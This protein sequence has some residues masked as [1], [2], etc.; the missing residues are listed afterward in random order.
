MKYLQLKNQLILLMRD[1]KKV[2]IASRYLNNRTQKLD[3]Q[4]YT[5]FAKFSSFFQVNLNT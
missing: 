4:N 3:S 1:W 5:Y 2:L